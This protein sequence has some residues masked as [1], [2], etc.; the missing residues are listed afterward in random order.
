MNMDSNLYNQ[1]Q[2][3]NDGFS[4][5]IITGGQRPEKL[6][7]LIQSIK[8]QQ[9]LKSEII[10]A[11]KLTAQ[12]EGIKYIP[13]VEEAGSGKVAVMRNR[14]MQ[15]AAYETIVMCDDDIVLDDGFV[16]AVANHPKR[17]D[18][19]CVGMRNPDGSRCWDWATIGGP[20]GHRLME[21]DERDEH[22]YVSSGIFVIRKKTLELG[23]FDEHLGF[24]QSEDV[25][26]SQRLKS[27]GAIIDYCR[28]A[29]AVHDDPRYTQFDDYPRRIINFSEWEN[30]TSEVRAKGVYAWGGRAFP[31]TEEV[32]ISL[33]NSKSVS[34]SVEFTVAPLEK[35][36]YNK[37]WKCSVLHAGVTLK[38]SEENQVL[39]FA[40]MLKAGEKKSFILKCNTT[41]VAFSLGAFRDQRAVAAYMLKPQ[42]RPPQTA[43]IVIP[44]VF[45]FVADDAFKK[46]GMAIFAPCMGFSD[47]S[48]NSR[49]M[50]RDFALYGVDFGLE[51]HSVDFW[52][53]KLCF[54]FASSFAEWTE[55]LKCRKYAGVNLV[56]ADPL[57]VK[58]G[59]FRR[60][61]SSRPG[62][63]FNMAVTG[64]ITA[65][66]ILE[67]LKDYDQVFTFGY[68]DCLDLRS[69]GIR[70][71]L[72][73]PRNYFNQ[74]DIGSKR[75]LPNQRSGSLTILLD[76]FSNFEPALRS[77]LLS[78]RSDEDISIVLY[79]VDNLQTLQAV[80]NKVQEV[81]AA[82]G[83]PSRISQIV[84]TSG[85]LEAIEELEFLKHSDKIKNLLSGQVS[86]EIMRRLAT[87]EIKNR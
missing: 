25:E 34:Q 12:I 63:S 20:S 60:A 46:S 77:D 49:A 59:F 70:A 40:I 79:V 58:A 26:F 71:D 68:Q 54:G 28:A 47:F 48:L 2:I 32:A 56:C 31:M 41:S 74:S 64:K 76:R 3:L 17:F 75:R 19:L 18:I 11:G 80:M 33:E 5:C 50:V 62:Y 8:R 22:V 51:F 23:Y 84:I 29:G 36:F 14:A 66:E 37:S 1:Q 65:P 87:L 85:T 15:S 44:E 52:F 78:V 24:Y 35:D 53:A 42:S 82:F 9:I 45:D 10:V 81:V 61:I 7:A 39:C 67:E 43:D 21:E 86:A 55:Y 13:L 27:K 4:F 30:L 57:E 69:T 73:H 83:E 16:S 6:N 72:L 38:E